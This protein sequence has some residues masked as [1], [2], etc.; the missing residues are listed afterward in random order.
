[1]SRT[2][3]TRIAKLEKDDNGTEA[4]A[5]FYLLWV[6]QGEDRVAALDRA[7]KEGKSKDDLPAY[8]A[9]WTGSGPRPRS[10]LTHAGRLSDQEVKLLWDALLDEPHVLEGVKQLDDEL[11]AMDEYERRLNRE[12]MTQFTDRELLG[13]F[14]ADSTTA[15]WLRSRAH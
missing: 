1:M 14:F 4:N 12:R 7:R 3:E 9:E 6:A 15:L 8:C 11:A 10:R 5:F 2:L 13:P